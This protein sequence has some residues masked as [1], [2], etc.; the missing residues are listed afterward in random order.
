MVPAAP[1]PRLVELAHLHGVA[2]DYWDWQG[3]H[4]TVSAA[5]SRIGRVEA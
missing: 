2:T 4:V 3:Q 5:A 1:P